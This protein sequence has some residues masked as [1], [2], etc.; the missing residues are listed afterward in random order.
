ME[1]GAPL[2][3]IGGLLTLERHSMPSFAA[4][5]LKHLVAIRRCRLA[6]PTRNAA[7]Q[8]AGKPPRRSGFLSLLRPG[9]RAGC[10]S[11]SSVSLI[12]ESAGARRLRYGCQKVHE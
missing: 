6:A 7:T 5:P 11:L 2:F 1:R 12:K 10:R 8:S 9:R 4:E 3:E